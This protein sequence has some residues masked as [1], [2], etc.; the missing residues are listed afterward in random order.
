MLHIREKKSKEEWKC[1]LLEHSLAIPSLIVKFLPSIWICILL[2]KFLV[3][4]QAIALLP[5]VDVG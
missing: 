2:T 5:S 4:R 3:M 1:P